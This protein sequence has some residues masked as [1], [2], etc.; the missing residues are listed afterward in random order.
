MF[1]WDPRKERWPWDATTLTAHINW[2][3]CGSVEW[4]NKWVFDQ[5]VS[6]RTT[7][8]YANKLF[9]V[10]CLQSLLCGFNSGSLQRQFASLVNAIEALRCR[11]LRGVGLRGRSGRR[12]RFCALI[13]PRHLKF[14]DLLSKLARSQPDLKSDCSRCNVRPDAFRSTYVYL[15][16]LTTVYT[17]G[18]F[19]SFYAQ[20]F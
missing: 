1:T 6:L 16:G 9:V 20:K 7:T 10:L 4:C 15:I 11:D 14:F 2:C 8:K 12:R 5:K 19:V 3:S 18:S 17:V 13:P